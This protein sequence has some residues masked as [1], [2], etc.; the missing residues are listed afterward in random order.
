[1]RVKCSFC[2]KEVEEDEIKFSLTVG[3]E[4][5]NFCGLD[6]LY[7]SDP[8]RGFTHVSLSSLV[9]NKTFFEILAIITGIG[10]I[11]YTLFEMGN[12]A[13]MMDTFSVVT[14]LTAMIIG[15]EHLRYVEKHMLVKRAV[16][17][18][19]LIIVIVIVLFVWFHGF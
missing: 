19:G 18:I 3:G 10:G 8:I 12:R 2:G 9:L 14:A 5:L 4:T 13:L 6:C 7:K 17:M 11:Y 15:I 1:M 16:V